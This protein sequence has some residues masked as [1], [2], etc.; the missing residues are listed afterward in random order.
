MSE[1]GTKR[2]SPVGQ[3][4]SVAGDKADI[5]SDRRLDFGRCRSSKC[6]SNNSKRRPAEGA[7]FKRR[8]R[9]RTSTAKYRGLENS[10]P[11]E[12]IMGGQRLAEYGPNR[13][14]A[15]NYWAKTIAKSVERTG[16]KKLVAEGEQLGSNLLRVD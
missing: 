11:L 16:S 9:F 5:D 3:P 8:N 15:C 12:K 1:S 13:G 6:K 10:G 7:C 14:E 2:T 4:M